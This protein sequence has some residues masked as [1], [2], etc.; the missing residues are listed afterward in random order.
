MWSDD[1]NVKKSLSDVSSAHKALSRMRENEDLLI[2]SVI[3]AH[4]CLE[5]FIYD[6]AAHHFSDAYAKKHLDKLDFLSKWVLIPKLVIGK[7][8]P[9]ESKA[10]EYLTK[11]NKHRNEMV[12]PKSKAM[13]DLVDNGMEFVKKLGPSIKKEAMSAVYI[14]HNPPFEMVM[15]VL[16]EL[17]KLE[18]DDIATQWWQVD[19]ITEWW[20]K[21]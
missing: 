14:E 4:M 1:E 19:E 6:Y 9:K 3:F 2:K 17:R 5:A 15:E 13:V 20:E 8:F 16:T 7:D 11:L 10:F 12:H 18:G 21:E